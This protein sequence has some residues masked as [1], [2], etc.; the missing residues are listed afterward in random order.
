VLVRLGFLAAAAMIVG[1]LVAGHNVQGPIVATCLGLLL[2]SAAVGWVA[3]RAQAAAEAALAIR[4]RQEAG[5]RL[6][7]LTARQVQAISA[8]RLAVAM[9][10][11]PEAIASLAVGHR[12]ARSMM[13]AG[14]LI[15]AGALAIVSWQAALT[16]L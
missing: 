3:D 4:L 11:Y 15:V 5:Q 16:V 9:Q 14:P 10:R 6:D 7:A 2:A 13:A 1:G 12:V 8:G